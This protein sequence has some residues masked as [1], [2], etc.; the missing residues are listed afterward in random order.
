L[1]FCLVQTLEHHLDGPLFSLPGLEPYEKDFGSE[2]T[3]EK[4][5]TIHTLD[6]RNGKLGTNGEKVVSQ[7][8]IIPATARRM[9]IKSRRRK[10][11]KWWLEVPRVIFLPLDYLPLNIL[12]FPIERES[13]YSIFNDYSILCKKC[14]IFK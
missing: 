3:K 1:V 5:P 14:T 12:H 4:D 9:T 6:M 8:M 10:Q 13:V 7:A 2:P 11:T